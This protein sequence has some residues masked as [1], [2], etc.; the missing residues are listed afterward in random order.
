[1]ER[2][3]PLTKWVD[4]IFIRLSPVSEG[5]ARGWLPIREFAKIAYSELAFRGGLY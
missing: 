2:K 1:M 5:T 3:G 4:T